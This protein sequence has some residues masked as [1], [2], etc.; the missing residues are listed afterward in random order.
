MPANSAQ[1]LEA[2]M[3]TMR[4]ASIRG[5]GGSTPNRRRRLAILDAAPELPLGG[6]DQV[7][8]ERIGVGRDLDP[9]AA[10]GDDREHRGPWPPT[11]HILC[12]SCGMYFSAAASSENDQGSMN[13]ASNTAP[14]PS[15]RPSRVAAIQRSAGCRT[16]RWMSVIDLPGI[17][18]VPAPIEVL[19]DRRQA[20]R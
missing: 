17:G 10:A 9:L 15:T 1:A 11:T 12:C 8:V 3:S 7:L 4:I 6:D 18:L 5:L 19:G 13:L 20:G 16:R 2:L 14:L